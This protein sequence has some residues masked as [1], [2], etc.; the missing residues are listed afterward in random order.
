V[1]LLLTKEVG[2]GLVLGLSAGY[3]TY[4]ML[5]RVDDYQV[6]ILLT[7][8]LAMGRYA[9][10]DLRHVSAP[11]AAVAAGL[12]IGNHGRTFAMSPKTREHVDT[13]WE[14]VDGILNAILFLLLGLE[15]LV[16]PFDRRFLIAGLAI[17]PL[18]VMAR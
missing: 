1:L 2:G 14:L 11:I 9:P 13:F 16:V 18:T 3:A 5:R 10:A 15:I 4:Q 12:L 8:A 6:E 17:V 7:V